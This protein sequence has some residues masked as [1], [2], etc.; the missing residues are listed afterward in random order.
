MDGERLEAHQREAAA[1]A[2]ASALRWRAVSR[3]G[4]A[5]EEVGRTVRSLNRSEGS[6]SGER[7]GGICLRL[8]RLPIMLSVVRHEVRRWLDRQGIEPLVAADVTLACSEACAN[9]LEHSAD[10]VRPAFELSGRVERG[11][12]ELRV[13]DFGRWDESHGGDENRGRGLGIMRAVMDDVSILVGRDG[14]EV[15]MHRRLD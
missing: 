2:R 9:A 1:R 15:R 3:R 5:L 4:Q 13:R 10:P 12:L 7:A 14:T 6:A 8:P 11:A